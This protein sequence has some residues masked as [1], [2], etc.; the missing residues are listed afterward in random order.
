[1]FYFLQLTQGNCD[2]YFKLVLMEKCCSEIHPSYND[3][4]YT[5]YINFLLYFVSLRKEFCLYEI[6]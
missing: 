5:A 1:M 2:D 6:I 3:R 4:T